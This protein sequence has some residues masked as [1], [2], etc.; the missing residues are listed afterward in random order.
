MKYFTCLEGV[1]HGIRARY[2][3]AKKPSTNHF[4]MLNAKHDEETA[5]DVVIVDWCKRAGLDISSS[6]WKNDRRFSS[7]R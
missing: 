2:V 3:S 4:S 1:G 7:D 6:K 5:R